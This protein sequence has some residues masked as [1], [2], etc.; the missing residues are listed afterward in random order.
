MAAILFEQLSLSPRERANMSGALRENP[1]PVM[2]PGD[3]E[4][5]RNTPT[6]S[7]GQ[8]A[9][10]L[11]FFLQKQWPTAGAVLD[12]Q[13]GIVGDLFRQNCDPVRLTTNTK[14]YRLQASIC[15][16]AW[17]ESDVEVGFILND[18]LSETKEFLVPFGNRTWGFK[19]SPKG[20]D[21]LEHGSPNVESTKVLIAGRFT[22][23]L[24]KFYTDVIGK[25]VEAC[26]YEPIIV[27][28]PESLEPITDQIIASIRKSRFVVSD[29][30]K[31]SNGAYFEGGFA[32]GLGLE[33]IWTCLE[34][35]VAQRKVHFDVRGLPIL[36]WKEGEEND[37]CKRLQNR[38]EANFGKGKFKRVQSAPQ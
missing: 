33:V 13:P 30:T 8:R 20:W 14:S 21:Y 23:E 18:Y 37:F 28:E 19:I 1:Q 10:K 16:V 7:V 17:A 3:V 36:P 4:R 31:Q 11:L 38:I 6:P 15:G 25:T 9:D 35:E 32:K 24:L 34:E 22:P 26:G 29:L 5:L 12:I 27:G 2:I